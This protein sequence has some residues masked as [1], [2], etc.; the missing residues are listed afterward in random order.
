MSLVNLYFWKTKSMAAMMVMTPTVPAAIRMANSWMRS[1]EWMKSMRGMIARSSSTGIT[2]ASEIVDTAKSLR[3]PFMNSMVERME[4]MR[5]RPLITD[6]LVGSGLTFSPLRINPNWPTLAAIARTN[7]S[8]KIGAMIQPTS[9]A[10]SA[11][12]R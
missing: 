5:P 6:I 10:M 12:T 11:N 7:N 2:I 3:I 4:N 9:V 1:R 8:R